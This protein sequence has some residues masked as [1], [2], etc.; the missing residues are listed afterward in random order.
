M[1]GSASG[2]RAEYRYDANGA[3]MALTGGLGMAVALI[4]RT[5]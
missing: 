2:G 1:A 4:I 3:S 5:R